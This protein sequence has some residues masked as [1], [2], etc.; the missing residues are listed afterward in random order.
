MALGSNLGDRTAHLDFAISRLIHLL[1]EIRVSTRH[2]TMPV[3]VT[4]DQPM[5]LN[6]VVYGRTALGPH[7]F[8][9]QLQAIE[10]ERGRERPAPNAPRTLDLDLILYGRMH[11]EDSTLSVP[12]PRFRER[13]FVLEPLAEVAPDLPDPV[14]GHTVRELLRRLFVHGR[15][16]S[17]RR[18]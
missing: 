18:P 15:P 17:G 4:G 2:E 5:Y 9:R 7:E 6:A 10:A 8:L 3:G 13:L 11:C 12:H 1:S 16:G 14:T